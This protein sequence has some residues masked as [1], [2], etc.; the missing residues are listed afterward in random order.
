MKSNSF[1]LVSRLEFIN[2]FQL[3]EFEFTIIEFLELITVDQ[4][5][6]LHC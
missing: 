6:A 5:G 3:S 1:Q 4:V 2:S